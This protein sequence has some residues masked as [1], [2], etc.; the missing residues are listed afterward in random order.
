MILKWIA[1]GTFGYIKDA[2]NIF[3]CIIVSI[4]IY[5]I[6]VKT[7]TTDSIEISSDSVGVSVLRTFRLFRIIKF[8]RFLPTMKAQLAMMLKSFNNVAS[9]LSLLS[10]FIFI[11][12]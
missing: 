1:Y 11:F 8:I 2:N 12:R 4:S 7:Q 6:I 9:F 10:L 5:E 3:D